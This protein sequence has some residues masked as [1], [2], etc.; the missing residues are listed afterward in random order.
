M[1]GYLNGSTSKPAH[2]LPKC[3]RQ[4]TDTLPTVGRLSAV[5]WP[6]VGRLSTDDLPTVG[7]QVYGGAVVQFFRSLICYVCMVKVPAFLAC[8][9][10]ITFEKLIQ[11]ELLCLKPLLIIISQDCLNSQDIEVGENMTD[12]ETLFVSNIASFYFKMFLKN[13]FN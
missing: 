1:G 3:H 10:P 8:F 4:V 13:V 5:Y 2:N 7:R 6:T 9:Y 11:L 12:G